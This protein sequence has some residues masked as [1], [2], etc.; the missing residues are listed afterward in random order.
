LV[1]VE[2][3]FPEGVE[4]DVQL[5]GRVGEHVLLEKAL[6]SLRSAE[7]KAE[8]FIVRGLFGRDSLEL[9]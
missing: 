9:E 4:V 3:C 1:A 2:L 6:D 8:G 7:S 5:D